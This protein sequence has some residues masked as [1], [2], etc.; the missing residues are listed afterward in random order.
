MITA[1]HN[2][3]M[4]NGYKVFWANGSQIVT[5]Y[6]LGIED[7]RS[8]DL[9]VVYVSLYLNITRLSPTFYF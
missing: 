6:D 2:P 4:D 7:A 1:S 8:K 5:P 9:F 3:K